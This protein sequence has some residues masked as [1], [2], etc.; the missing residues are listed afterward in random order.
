MAFKIA[1]LQ[2]TT[3]AEPKRAFE[4]IKPLFEAA[5]AQGAQLILTPECSNLMEQRKPQKE[6]VVTTL[7]EDVFVK[8]MRDLV[9]RY[10]LPCLLGSVIVKPEAG[11]LPVNRALYLGADGDI[12]AFYDKIHL[13]DATTPNG[14][15]YRESD[16]II[17]GKQAVIASTPL[18]GLGLSICYDIR[19]GYLQR[20]LAQ[21]GAEM[22][23]LPAAFTVPTGQA[24]WEIML[25]ARAIE[26]GCFLLAP[27]Q[28]G[29]H[30]DGRRTY[31]HSLVVG[32]WGEVIARLDHDRPGVLMAN[33]DL[34]EVKKARQALPQLTHDR[35]FVSP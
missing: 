29:V 20:S 22:I 11:S 28:G 21:G 31:G 25:R 23:A 8:A 24:H 34:T 15:V 33:I 26:T 2:T 12:E 17:G 13:F 9:R 19:F 16:G 1:L 32:P 18:G 14:D 4:H 7:N 3:P 35:T 6:A 27:A 10:Q 5:V 30:E